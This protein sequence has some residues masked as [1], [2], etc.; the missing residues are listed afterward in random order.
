MSIYDRLYIRQDFLCVKSNGILNGSIHMENAKYCFF[1]TQTRERAEQLAAGLEAQGY[2][3][4]IVQKNAGFEIW[5]SALTFKESA[6]R[7][8]VRRQKKPER[9]TRK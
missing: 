9:K 8:M 4:A 3:I 2:K 7:A 1:I 5:G 6:L